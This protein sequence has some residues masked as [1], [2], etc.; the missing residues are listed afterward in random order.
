M[1]V[2][3]QRETPHNENWIISVIRSFGVHTHF[4]NLVN[5]IKLLYD[6][7]DSNQ[8]IW[9][10][11]AAEQ[12]QGR[13]AKRRRSPNGGQH[14]N[15]GNDRCDHQWSIQN[16]VYDEN[17][18]GMRN[19]FRV[20]IITSWIILAWCVSVH[21]GDEQYFRNR[22]VWCFLGEPLGQLL[23]RTAS[24]VWRIAHV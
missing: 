13:W 18:V 7:H 24:D 4:C 17:W 12:G 11:Q 2:I 19:F 6:N 21:C 9:H 22:S 16:T 10:S 5:N 3:V 20:W 23:L 8:K 1:L 14:Q 15:I